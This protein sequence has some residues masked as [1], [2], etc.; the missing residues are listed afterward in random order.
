[1]VYLVRLLGKSHFSDFL[2]EILNQSS[3]SH[4]MYYTVESIT[5]S[6]V[7]ITSNGVIN[8]DSQDLTQVQSPDDSV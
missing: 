8:L 6:D 4:H 3:S 1:M 7:I 5:K 2:F